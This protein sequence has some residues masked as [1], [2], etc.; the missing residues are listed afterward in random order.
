M[1]KSAVWYPSPGHF[2]RGRQL[3][4]VVL[5]A[6]PYR[7]RLMVR[8][9][10]YLH[11]EFPQRPSSLPLRETHKWREAGDDEGCSIGKSAGRGPTIRSL[12]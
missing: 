9:A 10:F 4:R 2:L 1:G 8:L 5:S 3:A 6:T 11:P 12:I 7:L